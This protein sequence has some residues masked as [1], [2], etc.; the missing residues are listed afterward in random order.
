MRSPLGPAAVELLDA[1]AVAGLPGS[2]SADGDDVVLAVAALGFEKA[3]Q[4]QLADVKALCQQAGGVDVL[5]EGAELE[6]A[7]A[8][9]RE[10]TDPSARGI[11]L[12]KLAVPPARSAVALTAARDAARERGFTPIVQA[13]AGSGVVY[14]K[15]HPDAWDADRIGQLGGLV[16]RLRAFARGEGGS[17]VLEAGP[18]GA[19][20]GPDG[21]DP[22]GDVGSSFPV[23]RALKEN[24]DPKGTLNPSRFVGRL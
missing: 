22:W 8:H 24:L 20:Q 12:L 13:H 7:W 3:V 19:K 14:L 4:R 11:A 2:L 21:I 17:L 6:G 23:M 9:L 5:R 18:V 1:G 10:L 15:L 16:T